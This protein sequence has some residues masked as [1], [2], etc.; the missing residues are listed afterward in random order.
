MRSQP[1]MLPTFSVQF[2]FHSV[3]RLFTPFSRSPTL[4]ATWTV[5]ATWNWCFEWWRREGW[6][7]NKRIPNNKLYHFSNVFI[8]SFFSFSRSSFC[9]RFH[10]AATEPN[11]GGPPFLRCQCVCS[12]LISQNAQ[13]SSVTTP[14][15]PL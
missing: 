3:F 11:C 7:K 6:W 5:E 13:R 12:T 9:S 2:I 10:S 1:E 15:P 8:F 4:F 14:E